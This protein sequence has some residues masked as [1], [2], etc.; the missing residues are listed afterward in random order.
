MDPNPAAAL[1]K[2]ETL[3]EEFCREY[4]LVCGRIPES[5]VPG[6]RRPDYRLIGQVGTEIVVEVKQFDQNPEE[7]AAE[8]ALNEGKHVAT[9]GTPGARMRSAINDAGK[10]L[11]SLC[12]GGAPGLLVVYDNI[13]PFTMHSEPY[14]VLTAV[15]GLDQI[16]VTVPPDPR[17]R[18]RFG[19]THPG[20]KKKLTA[21][22]NR[23]ISAIAVLNDGF[24]GTR[25]TVYH[26]RHAV[27]PLSIRELVGFGIKHFRLSDDEQRWEACVSRAFA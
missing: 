12:I 19:S 13:R 17:D 23:T 3:F 9:G 26:N 15:R 7:I 16:D 2:A 8:R 6:E 20:P 25:L 10:Q 21:S 11:K 22:T 5:S 4:G 27:Q 24:N 14:G 1:T 18:P